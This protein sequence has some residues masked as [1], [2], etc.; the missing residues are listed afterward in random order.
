MIKIRKTAQIYILLLFLLF[1]LI[2]IKCKAFYKPQGLVK[3]Y[4]VVI[5]PPD[6]LDPSL[7]DGDF[8]PEYRGKTIEFVINKINL[9]TEQGLNALSESTAYKKYSNSSSTNYLFY[10]NIKTV[11]YIEP[12]KIGLQVLGKS[13]HNP[14][15][16]FYLNRENICDLVDKQGIS[17]IWLWTNHNT[18]IEPTESNM[19]M[20]TSISEFWNYSDYGDVSNSKR[21][22]DLP[23][24]KNTYTLYNYSFTRALGELLEN[25]THQ[26][27]S[28]LKYIDLDLF[29]KNFAGVPDSGWSMPNNP[30]CGWTHFPPNGTKDYDWYSQTQVLNDCED[31]NPQKTGEKKLVNCSTWSKDLTCPY[32][33]GVAFKTWWM[34]NIPGLNNNFYYNGKKLRNWWEYIENFDKAIQQ[35]SKL[36]QWTYGDFNNDN[37]TNAVDTNLL[38][39]A[40]LQ[41]NPKIFMDLNDDNV[42]N[43]PD[44]TEYLSNK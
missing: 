25:H 33:G 14:D 41:I 9:L 39:N 4:S 3:V 11:T 43:L 38:V 36:Y 27:E 35:K 13:T 20:G 28:I 31:W 1:L 23:I 18:I 21:T 16:I 10:N 26:I 22:K 12:I 29:W 15:Y 44:L 6:P 8:V 34:Q 7:I 42:V 5:I 2:P 17:E 32:D 40:V 19:S 24:C 30:G 37:T